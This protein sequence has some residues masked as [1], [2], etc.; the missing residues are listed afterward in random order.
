MLFADLLYPDNPERRL[1][2][3]VM[4]TGLKQQTALLIKTWNEV[5][6]LFSEDSERTYYEDLGLHPITE[7][8]SIQDVLQH[9]QKEMAKKGQNYMEISGKHEILNGLVEFNLSISE[10]LLFTLTSPITNYT[11]DIAITSILPKVISNNALAST[12]FVSPVATVLS[13]LIVDAYAGYKEREQ[14]EKQLHEMEKAITALHPVIY[15]IHA[16][17]ASTL[18]YWK[19]NIVLID[20]EFFTRKNK[21]LL[22][23]I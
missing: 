23:L 11:S 20:G 21:K 14:L 7:K 19:N 10:Q 9:I 17:L 22:I 8:Y 4:I 12:L 16:K 13:D 5:C 3:L 18:Y 15:M 2:L 6:T 1:N